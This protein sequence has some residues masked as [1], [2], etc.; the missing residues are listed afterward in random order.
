MTTVPENWIPFIPVGGSQLQRVSMLRTI[1]GRTGSL[2]KVRPRT[3]ILGFGLDESP[4]RPYFVYE[5]EVPRAGSRVTQAFQRAR[6]P[7]GR[8]VVWLGARKETGRGEGS[9]GLSFDQ[10]VNQDTST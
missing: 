5:E 9:S 4:Q 1:E 10:L 7:N 3:N 6:G 8:V 2:G